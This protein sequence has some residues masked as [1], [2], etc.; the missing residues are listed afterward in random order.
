MSGAFLFFLGNGLPSCIFASESKNLFFKS[1]EAKMNRVFYFQ[2]S[3]IS[4]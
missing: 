1:V 2:Q 3:I 4:M